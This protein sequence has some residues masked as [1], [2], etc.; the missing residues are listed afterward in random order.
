M[1]VFIDET[2][3]D[4]RNYIRKFGYFLRGLRAESHCYLSRGERILA[5]ADMD[6]TGLKLIKGTVD[7]HLI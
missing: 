2:G 5:I 3:S 1:F 7:S 4:D 6:C